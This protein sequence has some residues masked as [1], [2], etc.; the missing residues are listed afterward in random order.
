MI[1][2][3]KSSSLS[4]AQ[5][6]ELTFGINAYLRPLELSKYQAW[7]TLV[8]EVALY[9]PGTFPSDPDI[10]C[11]LNY[12]LFRDIDYMNNTFAE[13]LKSQV[14][15]Y[16]EDIPLN[17]VKFTAYKGDISE[18]A[19][20][21]FMLITFNDSSNLVTVVTALKEDGNNRIDYSQFFQ[22]VNL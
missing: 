9:T 3:M 12:H 5:K 8:L 4:N 20:V 6:T 1:R 22:I 7:G 19:G 18:Y 17:S 15:K 10:G 2:T 11:G 16:L 14:V 21:Y 13:K